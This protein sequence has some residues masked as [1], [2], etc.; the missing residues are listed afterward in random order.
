[1]K[2]NAAAVRIAGCDVDRCGVSVSF[3]FG[4]NATTLEI[5]GD[6]K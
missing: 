4:P 1:M 5:Q 6:F 3:A 2:V